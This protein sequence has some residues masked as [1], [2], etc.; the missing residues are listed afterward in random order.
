[1]ISR[2]C[3]PRC[4]R[5]RSKGSKKDW[6]N[7][8]QA[9]G[10]RIEYSSFLSD[11]MCDWVSGW[12]DRVMAIDVGS[13]RNGGILNAS[14]HCY[15]KTLHLS[16]SPFCILLSLPSSVTFPLHVSTPRAWPC[17]PCSVY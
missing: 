16:F 3:K 1:M 7:N 11:T 12:S 2:S 17:N 8:R 14:E 10:A 13:A 9:H 15:G 5:N 4:W 6:L